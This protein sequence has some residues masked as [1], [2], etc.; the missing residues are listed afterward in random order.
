MI[1][2][3]H[4]TKETII[5]L[6]LQFIHFFTGH[7]K[8]L[9]FC[10]NIYGK[11]INKAKGKRS[12]WECPTCGAVVLKDELK[13]MHV[14]KLD[15]SDLTYVRHPYRYERYLRGGLDRKYLNGWINEEDRAADNL[16]N[17][18]KEMQKM[19]NLALEESKSKQIS[20]T[21]IVVICPQLLNASAWGGYFGSPW[22]RNHNS[23]SLRKW[24][25]EKGQY[26]SFHV[27]ANESEYLLEKSLESGLWVAITFSRP[28]NPKHKFSFCA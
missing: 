27:D 24:W 15:L 5:K 6:L 1:Q 23:D 14:I 26:E 16:E 19:L 8:N 22:D 13:K 7:D 17:A 28:S 9:I 2:T 12:A 4:I 18:H 21:E 11:E 25:K 3:K 20:L 10:S